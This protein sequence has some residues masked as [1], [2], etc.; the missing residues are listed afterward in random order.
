MRTSLL[1][2]FIRGTASVQVP[3]KLMY[4][5]L[6][7]W[8][9]GPEIQPS[10]PYLLLKRASRMRMRCTYSLPKL[11]GL[12]GDVQGNDTSNVLHTG[13]ASMEVGSRADCTKIARP[14]NLV[15]I[16]VTK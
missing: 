12:L 10:K 13:L 11:W 15:T 7:H 4:H 2:D 14:T 16:Q 9:L 8:S 3:N 5:L 1:I 6:I